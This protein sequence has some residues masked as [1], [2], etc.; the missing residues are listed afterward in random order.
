MV[1]L[2]KANS[3]K[4]AS[5]RPGPAGRFGWQRG[6]GAFTVSVSQLA[7]VRRYVR[8]Q[9]GHHRKRTFQEEFRLMLERHQIAY[10][11]RY[12]WD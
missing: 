5:T 3:S 9:E 6:C 12:V 2:V 10:D 7:A 4:W 1:R 8:G 11:E